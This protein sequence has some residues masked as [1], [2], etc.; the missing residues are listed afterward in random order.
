MSVNEFSGLAVAPLDK[1]ASN[2]GTSASPNSGL[3]ATTTQAN[4]L[5][6]GYVQSIAWTPALSGSNPSETY[7]APPNSFPY[8]QVGTH[9]DAGNMCGPPTGSSAR[10]VSTRPTERV[11]ERVVG[12]R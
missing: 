12:E 4:E 5:V 11:A 8:T 7:A 1:V 6:F 10:S 9:H 2:S 3:T